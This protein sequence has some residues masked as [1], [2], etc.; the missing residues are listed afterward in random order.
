MRRILSRFS[1]SS[2]SQ[3]RKNRFA[4]CMQCIMY[5]NVH[6]C[7]NR[8]SRDLS[9]QQNFH[10]FLNLISFTRTYSISRLNEFQCYIIHHFS[11]VEC[12]HVSMHGKSIRRKFK[13]KKFKVITHCLNR[14]KV[15]SFRLFGFGYSFRLFID[16]CRLNSEKLKNSTMD[17]F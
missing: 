16:K 14:K 17:G 1:I 12:I 7:A 9:E 4:L 6:H 2:G 10:M 8:H 13:K 11:Y 15:R 3:S 5:A